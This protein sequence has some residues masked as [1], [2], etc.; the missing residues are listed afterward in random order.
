MPTDV[1]K[2]PV[3]LI[4]KWPVCWVPEVAPCRLTNPIVVVVT[5][6]GVPLPADW[7]I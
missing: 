7:R 5:H 2:R 3:P 1:P 4:L 6:T